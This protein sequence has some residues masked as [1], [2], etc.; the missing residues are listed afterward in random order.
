LGSA[1]AFFRLFLIPRNAF[2]TTGG[3]SAHSTLAKLT[4]VYLLNEIFSTS[5]PH[6]SWAEANQ[7]DALACINRSATIILSN[8]VKSGRMKKVAFKLKI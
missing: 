7:N 8:I 3:A 5:L 2:F 4:S 1:K 6:L